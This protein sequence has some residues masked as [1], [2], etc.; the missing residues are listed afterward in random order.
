MNLS[1]VLKTPARKKKKKIVGRGM[2][3][4]SGKSCGRG[5]KGFH[6]RSGNRM[7][8]TL[9]G[10]QM[11]LFRRL[12]QRGFNNARFAKKYTPV[13]L[14]LLEKGFADGE[15]VTAEALLERGLIDKKRDG[16]K[17]LGTGELTRKLVVKTHRVS[18]S[19]KEKI[20]KAGGE[21]ILLENP[22]KKRRKRK[23]RKKK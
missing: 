6:S 17:V 16:I 1:D 20:E 14:F 21:V 11:P 19:A 2:S 10:G 7:N 4:G 3:S 18:A 12:P 15:E 9:E 23:K 5:M 22:E 13:N 8:K